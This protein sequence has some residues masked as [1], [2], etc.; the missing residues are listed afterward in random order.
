[1]KQFKEGRWPPNG[2]SDEVD[3]DVMKF[4][5]RTDFAPTKPRNATA[6]L[7]TNHPTEA[8][9]QD[10]LHPVL[11]EYMKQFENQPEDEANTSSAHLSQTSSLD[12]DR[13]LE[14]LPSVIAGPAT[15]TGNFKS[16][17]S[18]GLLRDANNMSTLGFDLLSGS[19]NV[20]NGTS[21]L[22]SWTSSNLYEDP[23]LFL[24]TSQEHDPGAPPLP[25]LLDDALFNPTGG[26]C[27]IGEQQSQDQV[28]EQF[29]ST[30]MS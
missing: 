9:L 1:M 23:S 28:W 14:T 21:N 15:D 8:S 24:R 10:A 20:T 7:T 18:E 22:T 26:P 13:D 2:P 17:L 29:L 19:S 6:P 3:A 11:Y 30:L 5:G 4:I 12:F 27:T 16:S 25:F